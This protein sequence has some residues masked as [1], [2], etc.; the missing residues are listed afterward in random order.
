MLNHISEILHAEEGGGERLVAFLNTVYQA[1]PPDHTRSL[2]F[3]LYNGAT[4]VSSFYIIVILD[5]LNI[6]KYL[7][8]N[9]LLIRMI[10]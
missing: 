2:S 10:F 9:F 7:F 1:R 8:F 6:E 4:Q 3:P 5:Y